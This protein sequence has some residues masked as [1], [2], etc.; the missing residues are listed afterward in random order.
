MKTPGQGVFFSRKFVATATEGT[1]QRLYFV[2]VSLQRTDIHKPF[3]FTRYF[4]EDNL[5]G[6]PFELLPDVDTAKST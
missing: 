3:R 2:A 5:I 6:P 1:G 4:P